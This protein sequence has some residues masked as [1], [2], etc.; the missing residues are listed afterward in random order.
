MI[1]LG[2][3]ACGLAMIAGGLLYLKTEQKV[4]PLTIQSTTQD[5]RNFFEDFELIPSGPPTVVYWNGKTDGQR[6][7][8]VSLFQ[9]SQA[10]TKADKIIV[11]KALEKEGYKRYIEQCFGLYAADSTWNFGYCAYDII[12][13]PSGIEG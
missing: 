9:V 2:L 1:L 4:K 12:E 10:K 13:S 11:R 8:E 5:L 6:A 7:S 3:T